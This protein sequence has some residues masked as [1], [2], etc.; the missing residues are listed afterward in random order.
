MVYGARTRASAIGGSSRYLG[1]SL[2]MGKYLIYSYSSYQFGGRLLHDELGRKPGMQ[3][4]LLNG[5]R[6]LSLEGVS[7][8][9]NQI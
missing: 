2:N 8:F 7:F 1:N 4:Y 3:V 5:Y 6:P 9:H